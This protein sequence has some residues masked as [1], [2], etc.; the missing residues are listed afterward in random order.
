MINNN[1]SVIMLV[2]T[3]Q[4]YVSK[5]MF[6]T[7]LLKK[8]KMNDTKFVWGFF[9]LFFFFTQDGSANNDPVVNFLKKER[10]NFL[11]SSG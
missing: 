11:D 5:N 10:K 7:L 4:Q 9:C 6:P 2:S 8:K 1:I 3:C